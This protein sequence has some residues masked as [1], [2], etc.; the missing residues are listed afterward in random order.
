MV[1]DGNWTYCGNH[2]TVYT[3]VESLCSIPEMNLMLDIKYMSIKKW[4]KY[5]IIF[6]LYK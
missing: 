3:N 2:F 4:L 1:T 5:I 6:G